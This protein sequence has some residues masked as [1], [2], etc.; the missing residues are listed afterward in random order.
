MKP[1]VILDA[2]PE[3]VKKPFLTY[4]TWQSFLECPAMFYFSYFKKLQGPE[5]WGTALGSAWDDGMNVYA[6]SIID[7]KPAVIDE[8]SEAFIKVY[9]SRMSL[10]EFTDGNLFTSAE[11]KKLRDPD[12]GKIPDHEF[13]KAQDKA[14]AFWREWGLKKIVEYDKF[15]G[16]KLKPKYVQKKFFI[17]FGP[18]IPFGLKGTM[19]R[20]DEDGAVVDNKTSKNRWYEKDVTLDMQGVG[21]SLAYRIME[22]KPENRVQFDVLVKTKTQTF[23]EQF[24][25]L[26]VGI[27]PHKFDLLMIEL[28]TVFDMIR[29]GKLFRNMHKFSGSCSYCDFIEDCWNPSQVWSRPPSEEEV[30]QFIAD[31]PKNEAFLDRW[32]SS[33]T[34]KSRLVDWRVVGRELA[35]EVAVNP[36]AIQFWY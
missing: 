27:E 30:N 16:H 5:G 6:Q 4:S 21:Y 3:N 33:E 9:D 22:G 35:A 31:D 19:D 8:V 20:I 36:N 13:R 7:G 10:A 15:I 12:T 23:E 28:S 34:A 18:D 1:V 26:V 29:E 11:M 25:Q 14:K 32:I 2:K 17:D 24:Q